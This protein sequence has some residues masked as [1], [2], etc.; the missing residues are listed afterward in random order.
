MLEYKL[1]AVGLSMKR[2]M[3]GGTSITC[4]KCGCC[5]KNNRQ[6]Q[7]KFVCVSCGFTIHADI[8]AAVQTARRGAMTVKKGDKLDSLHKNMVTALSSRDD[9]GLGPLAAGVARGLVA[10]HV[11]GTGLNEVDKTLNPDLGQNVT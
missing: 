2:V 4:S 5:D 10:G 3:A 6:K 7:D 1:N 8:N 9:S 11:S